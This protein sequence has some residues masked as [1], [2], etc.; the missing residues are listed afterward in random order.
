MGFE[1]DFSIIFVSAPSQVLEDIV[2]TSR[3]KLHIVQQKM[4]MHPS[5]LS[6]IAQETTSATSSFP[7]R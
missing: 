1:N 5:K 4:E 2:L 6:D 3:E 7:V